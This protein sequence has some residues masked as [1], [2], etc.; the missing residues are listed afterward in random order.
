MGCPT[1]ARDGHDVDVASLVISV[2]ITL[3]VLVV[4]FKI[5][6]RYMH[7]VSAAA[8]ARR[9]QRSPTGEFS[10]EI[11]GLGWAWDPAPGS[12]RSA[13]GGRLAGPGRVTYKRLADGEI[14]VT[15]EGRE[16]KRRES[17][18]PLPRALVAGTPQ[19]SRARHARRFSWAVFAFYPLCG[20]VGFA[21]GY[22]LGGAHDHTAR[23]DHG[24]VGF[25]VG[26]LGVAV[27]LHIITVAVG[28]SG[29]ASRPRM[30]AKE[31]PKE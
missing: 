11:R 26:F 18:G 14:H 19:A 7:F 4:I 29:V 9:L 1:V 23:F 28:A 27:L 8:V 22:A 21:V 16:G 24:L 20:G 15:L 2:V 17:N 10:A 13:N 6:W 31:R 25:V 3:A 12:G 30:A 5:E